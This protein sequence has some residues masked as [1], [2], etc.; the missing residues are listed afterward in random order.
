[1][2]TDLIDARVPAAPKLDLALTDR[3]LKVAILAAAGL[4]I[5]LLPAAL[6]LAALFH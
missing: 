2:T 6:A 4:V 3:H 5:F 1:M